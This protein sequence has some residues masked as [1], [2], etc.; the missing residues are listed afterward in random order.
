MLSWNKKT[1]YLKQVSFKHKG[2]KG[3]AQ[4]NGLPPVWLLL[5]ML[6]SG[7]SHIVCRLSFTDT[8]LYGLN[9]MD[10]SNSMLSPA[11]FPLR[12]GQ[13][14]AFCPVENRQCDDAKRLFDDA[15]KRLGEAG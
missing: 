4:I 13:D 10:A 9:N 14:L 1:S 8:T 11:E 12:S 6:L 5:F 7:L 2:F 15:R 3:Y